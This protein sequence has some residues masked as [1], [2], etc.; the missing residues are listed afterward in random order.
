MSKL[1]TGFPPI[2]DEHA[3]ILI[4]GSMPSVQ[5][6]KQQHYY[7]H[8]RNAFWS[9]MSAL[10]NRDNACDY[11]QRC[12]YLIENNIAVWDVLKSC[13]RQGSLD[14]N[15]DSSSIITNDFNA[16]FKHHP[17]IKHLFFNGGKAQ[18]VYNQSVLATL[19]E[20][21]I[22]LPQTRLPS[23]SPAYAAMSFRQKLLSWQQAILAV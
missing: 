10:C 7:A 18:Q 11:Q 13:Q 15:I 5:S 21:F 19:D 9:I 14:N 3:K 22:S 2:A 1:E 23:T 16:F 8:P 12:L 17:K 4:L 20:R 6:L